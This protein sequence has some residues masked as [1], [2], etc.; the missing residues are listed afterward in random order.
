MPPP[1]SPP[2]PQVN[3][4]QNNP[5]EDYGEFKPAD[6]CID[7]FDKDMQRNMEENDLSINP[8]D[9]K[10]HKTAMRPSD[11][12]ASSNNNSSSS[13][14]GDKWWTNVQMQ[15]SKLEVSNMSN[16]ENQRRP[17]QKINAVDYFGAK[18]E[19]PDF[20]T[21][22]PHNI[23]EDKDEHKWESDVSSKTIEENNSL[24]D[25]TLSLQSKTAVTT[26][27]DE[28]MSVSNAS[29]N[30]TLNMSSTGELIVPNLIASKGVTVSATTPF[31][32]TQTLRK[33]T[34][35]TTEVLSQPKTSSLNLKSIGQELGKI[36]NR[37]T[38]TANTNNGSI[39]CT[40]GAASLRK[41][42]TVSSSKVAPI[43]DPLLSSSSIKS[44][45]STSNLKALMNMDETVSSISSSNVTTSSS[46]SSYSKKKASLS[47]KD[48]KK[49]ALPA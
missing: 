18:S 29:Y 39:N 49:E 36:Q 4:R 46:M 2:P 26:I 10:V 30:F 43:S 8:N 38:Y 41:E 3:Q 42:K 45:Q 35:K 34:T 25:K 40:S 27:T 33:S 28:E 23:N 44:S 20:D 6:E 13:G 11:E 21:N 5:Y 7:I 14:G 19:M 1:P 15:N 47:G 16:N 31:I 22:R 32:M 48:S 24:V 37:L 12:T 9:L 17:K